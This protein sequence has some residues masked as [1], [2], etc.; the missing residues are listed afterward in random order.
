MAL[1]NAL[2]TGLSGLNVNQTKLNVVGNNIA[3][4]NTVAFKSSRVLFKPQFYVTDIAGGPPTADFGGENPSQRGLGSEVAA[5]QKDFAPGSIEP[6]GRATDLAIDGDG[7]F[8]VQGKDQRYTRDGSFVLNGSNQ[9][10]T[11]VGD[12]VQGFGV[13]DN[14]NIVTGSLQNIT[15]PLGSLTSAKATENVKLEGNLNAAGTIATG[16]SILNSQQ[17]TIVNGLGAA[18]AP[19]ATTLLTDLAS[20]TTSSTPLFSV[21]Q[22][23]TLSGKKGGRDLPDLTYTI[24]AGST[25]G[26]LSNFFQ[27]GLGIDTTVPDDG[28]PLTPTAGVAIEQNGATSVI[29]IT[30]NLGTDNA[31]SMAGTSLITDTGGTPL[32]FDDNGQNAAGIQSDPNGETVY[33]S[34]VAYDSLG[35]PLTINMTAVLESKADTGN[36]WRFYASS[37]DD[38]DAATFDPASG[39][40]VG[41]ILGTGTLTFDS[42][43]K[44]L[45]SSGT[46]LRVDRTATG[47]ATPLN[48]QLDFDSMTSLTT[49]SSELVM[50]EQDGSSTGTLNGFSIGSNGMITGSFSNG[51]TR[52]LGQIAMATFNNNEGLIDEGGGLYS[53]GGNSGVP[54]IGSPLQLGA[55]SIRS[56]ALELSNVDI[57]AEFINMIIA[58]TGFSASSRVITTSD[59]LLT[60]LLNTSR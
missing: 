58:S 56:G 17:L 22:T 11:N 37:A 45:D 52:T 36:V 6:T 42:S 20:T 33:T 3:N 16:A 31:L 59:Q 19:D 8:I 51:L 44:L 34:F 27:Q 38:T 55:G 10:V 46:T 23:L 50:T 29:T 57:S 35:T 40:F 32:V 14:N 60:E 25:L 39:N 48:I 24:D 2:F 28:D 49:R 41:S 13:D 5:I 18:P 47:A 21:G 43:G 53:A 1:T 30:G 9:L 54:V 12:F 26:D 4:T 7:F 15:I